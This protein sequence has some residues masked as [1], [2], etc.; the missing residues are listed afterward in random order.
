MGVLS[1][2]HI[3]N[4]WWL[5]L[6]VSG[7]WP[8]ECDCSLA[9]MAVSMAVFVLISKDLEFSTLLMDMIMLWL[10]VMWLFVGNTN[11]MVQL[12]AVSWQYGGCIWAVIWLYPLPLVVCLFSVIV[13][14]SSSDCIL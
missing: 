6:A 5:A 10:P 11:V 9:V 8:P 4:N 14:F 1:S 7:S 13:D 2:L 3:E 12:L